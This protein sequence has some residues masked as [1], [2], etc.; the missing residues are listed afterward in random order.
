VLVG[1]PGSFVMERKML[2]NLKARAEHA[3]ARSGAPTRKGL[4]LARELPEVLA[5]TV[6][7]VTEVRRGPT[8]G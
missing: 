1:D 3:A 5:R 8:P 2:L 6:P 7:G 4:P